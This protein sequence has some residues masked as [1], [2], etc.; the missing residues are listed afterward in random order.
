ML[1]LMRT[2]MRM[3]CVKHPDIRVPTDQKQNIHELQ[4]TDGVGKET[5]IVREE[6]DEGRELEV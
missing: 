5:L 3:L 1:M 2:Q 4:Q 6:G